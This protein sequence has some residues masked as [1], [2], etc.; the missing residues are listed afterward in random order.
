MKTVFSNADEVIHLFAQQSQTDA[1]NSSRNIYMEK[2]C[3]WKHDYANVIYSYGKH[4]ELARFIDPNTIL[5]NNS[6]HSVTTSK[7]IY[8]VTYGTSQYRRFFK[9]ETDLT[10]VLYKVTQLFNKWKVARKPEM[11]VS[12]INSLWN[13]LNEYIDYRKLKVK[14][15]KRYLEIKNIHKSINSGDAE[16]VNNYRKKLAKKEAAK[17]QKELE[18]ALTEFYNY[19]RNYIRLG[20]EKDYLRLSKD[21]TKVETTQNISVSKESARDLYRAIKS[22]VSIKGKRIEQY[23]VT[24][25]NGTLKIGCHDIDMNSV[26]KVGNQIIE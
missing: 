20:N 24:S 5:I 25:I 13:S 18:K 23:T 10:S 8:S 11:Y 21:G 4:Y 6:G 1:K 15:D 2:E 14:R 16:S 7:H 3:N 17:K 22:G 12:Q 9:T 19:E 26:H